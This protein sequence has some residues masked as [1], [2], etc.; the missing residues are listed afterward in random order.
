MVGT[1]VVLG[2]VVVTGPVPVLPHTGA[3]PMPHLPSALSAEL[4]GPEIRRAFE[5]AAIG[6]KMATATVRLTPIWPVSAEW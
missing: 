5:K 1:V 2:M 6:R 4:T 3:P